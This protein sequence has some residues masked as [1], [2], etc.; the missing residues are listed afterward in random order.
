MTS[1]RINIFSI[2]LRH[3]NFKITVTAGHTPKDYTLNGTNIENG[4]ATFGS[5]NPITGKITWTKTLQKI[6]KSK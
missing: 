6:R 2:L 4:G 3:T 1:P 5:I